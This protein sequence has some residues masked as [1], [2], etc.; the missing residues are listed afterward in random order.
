MG[1]PSK[2]ARPLPRRGHTGRGGGL[3]LRLSRGQHRRGDGE[4]ERNPA[5]PEAASANGISTAAVDG[6]SPNNGCNPGGTEAV[7]SAASEFSGGSSPHSRPCT[8][9]NG[10][11]AS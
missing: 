3:I 5:H 8:G 11:D 9:P 4:C 6:Q 10:T 2:S 7:V 1:S